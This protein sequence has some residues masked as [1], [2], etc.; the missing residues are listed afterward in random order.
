MKKAKREA[1]QCFM[2]NT[3]NM[4]FP[5]HNEYP[6]EELRQIEELEG[7]ESNRFDQY[8]KNVLR[9]YWMKRSIENFTEGII[10]F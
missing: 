7:D 1:L 10:R 8:D 4:I 3:V 9:A 5:N 6:F 2:I